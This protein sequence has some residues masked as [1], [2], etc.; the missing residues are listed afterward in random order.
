MCGGP[1]GVH[2]ARFW[3]RWWSGLA[4]P[5]PPSGQALLFPSALP[6]RA[7]TVLPW[8]GGGGSVRCPSLWF[9]RP[10]DALGVGIF[11]GSSSG[12]VGRLLSCP[13]A[14]GSLQHAGSSVKPCTCCEVQPSVGFTALQERPGPGGLTA[15][16]A[17]TWGCALKGCQPGKGCFGV[18]DPLPCLSCS[19]R[20][21]VPKSGFG[22]GRPLCAEPVGARMR[23]VV[24]QD[25]VSW[26][27]GR[28]PE[29]RRGAASPS[30][31]AESARLRGATG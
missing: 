10:A 8:G 13:A 22:R 20:C 27:G 26:C 30:S 29:G 15:A 9:L 7:T 2:C 5:A 6:S 11:L 16:Q 28:T 25:T 1:E 18:E 12:V 21:G 19:P 3:G 4:P 17:R 24:S 14:A 23:L 31:S